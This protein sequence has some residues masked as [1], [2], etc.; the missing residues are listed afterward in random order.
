MR[1]KLN[2][3][4]I[5]SI[6]LLSN[7]LIGC[8]QFAAATFTETNTNYQKAE[9]LL[10]VSLPSPLAADKKMQL[11][12]LDDVTGLPYNPVRIEMIQK[13]D[14][15]YYVKS[16]FTV[17]SILKYRYVKTSQESSVEFSA[18][19]QQVRFRALKVNGPLVVSDIIAA[20]Q[21]ES[22]QGALGRIRGQFTDNKDNT[23]LPNLLI[24]AEGVQTITASDGSFI[25]EGLTPGTHNLVVISMDGTYDEF[26]QNALIAEEATTPVFLSLEKRPLV[27]VAFEVKLPAGVDPKSTLRLATNFYSLGNLYADVFSGATALAADLPTLQPD[28]NGIFSLKLSLPVG[29]HLS[30]KYTLGDGFWNGELNSDGSFKVREFIVPDKN[31]TLRN[32]VASFQPLNSGAIH[33]EVTVPTETPL[34]DSVSLQLNPYAWTAPLPMSKGDNNTWSFTLYNPQNYFGQMI[35]RFCRNNNCDLTK[36]VVHPESSYIRTIT[37]SAE[38]Q[39]I[40]TAV[41]KWQLLVPSSG[42]TTVTIEAQGTSARPE[43][44]SG[45]EI[46]PASSIISRSTETATYRSIAATAANWLILDP[47]WTAT[48]VNPPLLEPV[49]GTDLLW[50]DILGSVQKAKQQNLSVALFPKVNFPNN[51]LTYWSAAQKDN[52]WWQSWFDRYH[53]FMVQNADAANLAGA[54]AI[55][56]GDVG[57][58][59]A[60]GNGSLP[61]GTPSNLPADADAQWRQLIQDIRSR[62]SGAIVGAVNLPT[63]GAEL[64]AWLDSVDAL[65]LLIHPEISTESSSSFTTIFGEVDAYFENDLKPLASQAN[66][67]VLIGLSVASTTD[68][69]L[70][71]SATGVDCSQDKSGIGNTENLDLDLQ[72]K[73]YN[74]VIMSASGKPWINGFFARGF[75][76]AGNLQDTSDSVRGKP[77]NDVLW[78]W[79]HFLSGDAQ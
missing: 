28:S 69:Y 78:Y 16:T 12:I 1:Q 13:D 44:L 73:M 75:Q 50:P 2:T 31:T 27:D 76:D 62:F 72:A 15:N 39:T 25:L 77:A 4:L 60:M 54:S 70:G 42:A 36:E 66:K 34:E 5:L 58:V 71:C 55:I 8:S 32:S 30:Y 22:Y 41:E 68:A 65:Y 40:Q 17:G 38:V 23:P 37:P 18:K 24:T 3:I 33:F 7:V 56:L 79:Y 46:D 59:P 29:S 47:T 48:W 6:L 64:P 49:P 21:D 19:G 43:F 51:S 11:E 45:F 10:E 20:W 57:L 74:A 35:Y 9:V 52:G 26:Q 67:P 61:D 14:R 63:Q 53:R